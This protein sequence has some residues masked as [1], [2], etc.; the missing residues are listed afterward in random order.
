MT[1]ILEEV[2]PQRPVVELAALGGRRAV[3]LLELHVGRQDVLAPGGQRPVEVPH[4]PV[5]LVDRRMVGQTLPVRWVG[6]DDPVELIGVPVL[7][8]QLLEGD[9][10]GQPRR[11]AVLVSDV[12]HVLVDVVAVDLQFDVVVSCRV[13]LVAYHVGQAV[14]S[15]VDPLLTDEGAVDPRR[16]VVPVQGG[17]DRDRPRTADRVNKGVVREPVGQHHQGRRHVFLERRAP[18]VLPV[19]PLEETLPGGV[20]GQQNVVLVDGDLQRVQGPGF[21]QAGPPVVEVAQPLD[22]RLLHDCLDARH[23]MQLGVVTLPLDR[24]LG[25]NRQEILPGQVVGPVEQL[26]K[27]AGVELADHDLDPVRG[28]Q[29]EVGPQDVLHVPLVADPTVLHPGVIAQPAQFLADQGLDAG[30]RRCDQLILFQ[31]NCS[32]VS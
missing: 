20:E 8:R 4:L 7:D 10:V 23:V 21:R 32:F 24:E 25:I 19:A 12:D 6:D 16:D 26:L 2:G 17:L 3:V 18:L 31:N 9:V 30:R 5:E 11:P 28:P 27:A 13:R 1:P 22:D 15:Q 14:R 29:P